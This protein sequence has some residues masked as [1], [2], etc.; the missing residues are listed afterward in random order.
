[1][2]VLR[3][4]KA[5][6]GEKKRKADVKRKVKVKGFAGEETLNKRKRKRRSGI[7]G[8]RQK[9]VRKIGRQYVVIRGRM[10]DAEIVGR[11]KMSP[12]AIMGR[13]VHDV[14]D[15]SFFR[16]EAKRRRGFRPSLVL[17]PKKKCNEE[18][19][20]GIK[21]ESISAREWGT[22]LQ[23]HISRWKQQRISRTLLGRFEFESSCASRMKLI[24]GDTDQ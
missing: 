19:A 2:K 23:S 14:G 10:L 1:M 11:E 24:M 6:E 4:A 3:K 21:A 20:A 17:P 15:S 9:A 12:Y 22:L 16:I 18:D 13:L 5:A 8:V 7:T